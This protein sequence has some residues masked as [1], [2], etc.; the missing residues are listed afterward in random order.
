[1][2]ES[3]VLLHGFGATRH[4]WDGVIAALDGERYRPLA[5]DLPGHG[6]A[7]D[8]AGPVTFTACVA[9]VLAHSPERFAL[10]GYSMGGRVALHLALAA[11][12]RVTRVLLVSS[13]AGI[14]D[15]A[16]RGAR[17]A[18]DHALADEL[19][20]APYEQFIDRW[21]AQP[22]FAGDPPEVDRLAR[23]DQR[24]N[25]PE[26]LAAVLRGIGTGEMAP[27]WSRLGELTMPVSVIAG[28]RDAKF[29]ELGQRM[30]ELLADA[31]MLV[32]AGG[33]VLALE[34]PAAVAS[35]LEGDAPEAS[36]LAGGTA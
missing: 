29:R 17:R 14:E 23:A 26:A 34:N 24:R 10:C 36:L 22:L 28:D 18:A 20:R 21:R 33:H 8:L 32:V 3:V 30:V 6:D 15:E 9:H 13:T 4:A 31:E 7:A 25:R 5:L 11:P 12:E 19:E 2:P 1:M 35:A 27:L 16:K